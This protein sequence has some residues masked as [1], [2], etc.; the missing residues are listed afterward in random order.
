MSATADDVIDSLI[1]IR[2]YIRWGA[3]RFAESKIYLGHG[4]LTPLDEAAAIVL[5]TVHQPYDLSDPY[6][7]TRLT[8]PERSLSVKHS[9]I[10]S[11]G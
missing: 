7:E 11:T 10:P 4:T 3:S 5:H 1:S 9:M 6:L 2:D 8:L